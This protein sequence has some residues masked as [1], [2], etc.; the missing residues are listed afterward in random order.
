MGVPVPE[1]CPPPCLWIATQR[2]RLPDVPRSSHARARPR[3]PCQASTGSAGPQIAIRLAPSPLAPPLRS[4][5]GKA[6]SFAFSATTKWPI[7]CMEPTTP[8]SFTPSLRETLGVHLGGRVPACHTTH[9]AKV[10]TSGPARRRIRRPAPPP[11]SAVPATTATR[12]KEPQ[13]THHPS[14][15]GFGSQFA[16]RGNRFM[17]N[18]QCGSPMLEV[19]CDSCHDPHVGA[20][21]ASLA[22]R[23]R[24]QAL[25][26]TAT[27]TNCGSRVPCTIREPASGPRI[28]VSSPNPLPR[29]SSHPRPAKSKAASGRRSAGEQAAGSLCEACHRAGRPG[30][31]AETPHVGKAPIRKSAGCEIRQS[32]I[33]CPTCH[34]IH[35]NKQDSKAVASRADRFRPLPRVPSRAWRR[36]WIRLTI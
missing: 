26:R 27:R 35:Q 32:V 5:G 14:A 4:C 33:S 6:P 13:G 18:P 17:H 11:I 2:D 20:Q 30:P 12:V 16:W 24:R 7:P 21:S 10:P 31:V 3:H 28:W 8:P 25:H 29:L 15:P 9:N 23:H 1:A 19:S 36:S 34:D 22:S